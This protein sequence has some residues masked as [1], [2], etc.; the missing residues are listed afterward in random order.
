MLC[1]NKALYVFYK[2]LRTLTIWESITLWLTSC[3]TEKVKLLYIQH[4]EAVES[5]QNT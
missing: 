2:N 3:L 4:K 1:I 5:K